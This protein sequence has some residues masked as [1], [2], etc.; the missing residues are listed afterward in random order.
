MLALDGIPLNQYPKTDPLVQQIDSAIKEIK[1]RKKWK[2][3]PHESRRRKN[4]PGVPDSVVEWNAGVS[5]M[6]TG[7]YLLGGMEHDITYYD[8]ITTIEGIQTFLPK[9]ITFHEIMPLDSTTQ[10]DLIFYMTCVAPYCAPFDPIRRFQYI[11]D[12]VMP[13]YKVEDL[14]GEAQIQNEIKR[15]IAKVN[16][17]LWDDDMGLEDETLKNIAISYGFPTAPEMDI[18]L[19]KNR[20]S[21]SLF[22]LE[23]GKYNVG[24]IRAF[25]KDT[26]DDSL[27]KLRNIVRASIEKKFVIKDKTGKGSSAWYYTSIYGEKDAHIMSLMKGADP[28]TSLVQYLAAKPKARNAFEV[29][30]KNRLKNGSLENLKPKPIS[31]EEG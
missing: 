10:A 22:R 26:K 5:P 20:L 4:A 18:E 11:K 30:Y 2:L 24:R 3:V 19:L 6:T 25:L 27:L 15:D 13:H 23:N 7:K 28:E 12:N 21:E 1:K 16:M 8:T 9:R 31:V 17:L 14:V 29:H